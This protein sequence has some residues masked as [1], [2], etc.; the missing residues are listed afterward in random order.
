M[1]GVDVNEVTD[2]DKEGGCENSDKDD[3]AK[4]FRFGLGPTA[5]GL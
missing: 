5:T 3:T 2:D 4:G 1:E